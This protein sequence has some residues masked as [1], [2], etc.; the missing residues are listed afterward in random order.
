MNQKLTSIL[1][2][3]LFA[4]APVFA[5]D[6]GFKLHGSVSVGGIHVDDNDTK[7]ASKLNEYRDLS[8]GLLTNF[9]VK[10][11][12]NGYWLDAFGENF[13]R[14]DQ[15]LNFRGGVYDIFKYR[16][17]SDALKH[18]FLFNGITPYTGAGSAA[19]TATFPSLTPATWNPIDIGYKRRDDG[20]NF[21][22]QGASP[23]YFRADANQVTWSGS[24]PGASSQGTSPGNG[25][26]DLAFPV[27][28]KTRNATFEGGYNTKTMHF[29][30]AWM[31]SK[32]ENSNES[33]TWTNG[34]FGNGTDRTYLAPDNRYTRLAGNATFRQLPWNSTVAARYTSDELKS[35]AD[36]GASVLNGTAGQ[37]G[38][39]GPSTATFNGKVRNETFT[40]GLS[41]SPTK[42]LDARAYLNYRKRDDEST[43][44]S[45]NSTAIPG[46]FEN[47]PFSYKKNNY[48]IDAYYR[49][50][51]ANRVGA[52]WDYLDT[53]RDGRFDFDRTK[54]HKYFVEWKN[55][56]LD[57]LAARLKYTYLDRNS[58][59]LLANDGTGTTDINYLNRF[60]TAFDVSNVNQEQWKLTL[61]YSPM[62]SLDVSFEGIV[63]NNKYKDNVLGRQKD[64]RRE[65]YLSVSYGHTSGARL[66]VF[67]DAEEIRYDSQH[68]I[69][70]TATAAGAYDPFAP[71][72][73]TNYDWTGR[74]KDRNWAF[75][76]AFDWPATAKLTLKAS[77]IYYK[78]DGSVDLALQEG[79]P[80]SV[81]RPLPIGTW[82]D[83]RKT[84]FNL[85]A[86]YAHNKSWS[87]TAGYAYE[88][89]EYRDSQFDGYRN[90]I[91]AA[92]RQDSYLDG[93]YANPQ[94]K[95]N[96]LYG[97]VSYRF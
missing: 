77:A 49:I 61:D 38:A 89:Y 95:A 36:L 28:Y 18:N 43:H 39:T 35:S 55:S 32:F 16:V 97:L 75:G 59:F 91:P 96:I 90:T 2:A 29:D 8:S 10:G 24:K 19:N 15:Y 40:L 21:E 70:G 53:K 17:Y 71:A 50:N 65:F 83:S 47:E 87:F 13:G 92:T 85:K 76:V 30:L 45:F 6:E 93:V 94:Y 25:F 84:S 74:I 22:F 88:K 73:A 54:D 51:R 9:D 3:N 57:E 27:D 78:T 82:D 23:W 42:G 60:V 58:N 66:T 7:D 86:V 12:G 4:A 31:T 52:G 5:D 44:V 81:V 79:T 26:V 11:R 1:I 64:D 20:F 69:I 14:D 41:S 68:R 37:I 34:Y 56:S 72:T 46:P 33:V 62:P 63:K 67:G 48:G 80:A